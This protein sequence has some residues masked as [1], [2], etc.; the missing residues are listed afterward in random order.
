[1]LLIVYFIAAILAVP[2]WIG[3]SKL[4]GKHRALSMAMFYGAAILS[5]AFVIPRHNFW[6]MF[7]V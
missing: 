6:V 1:M 5:L 4:V 3:I 7:L 2:F